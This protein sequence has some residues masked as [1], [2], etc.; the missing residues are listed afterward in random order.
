MIEN[1]SISCTHVHMFIYVYV[2]VS[3]HM[4]LHIYATSK[5]WTKNWHKGPNST[6]CYLRPSALT[7]HATSTENPAMS[8]A[9]CPTSVKPNDEF[10]VPNSVVC[11][12]R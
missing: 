4:H 8:L 6:Q 10:K 7:S 9:F 1:K 12:C 2:F 5:S 11:A 3:V